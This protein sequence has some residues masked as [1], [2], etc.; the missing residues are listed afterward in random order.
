MCHPEG[1]WC[2][3]GNLCQPVNAIAPTANGDHVSAGRHGGL[4]R[5]VEGH[6]G[7]VPEQREGRGVGNMGGTCP[8]GGLE[9]AEASSAECYAPF[10]LGSLAQ[11]FSGLCLLTHFGLLLLCWMGL[12]PEPRFSE[13]TILYGDNGEPVPA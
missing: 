10:G 11:S 8:G 5:V 12:G 2:Q 9:L 6:G 3:W 13:G 1:K 4:E 7:G